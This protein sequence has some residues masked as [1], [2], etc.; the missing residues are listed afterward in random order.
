MN[1][2]LTWYEI[3]RT[4]IAAECYTPV[5]CGH[6]DANSFMRFDEEGARLAD[7]ECSLASEDF[8]TYLA[9]NPRHGADW[10][11]LIPMLCGWRLWRAGLRKQADYLEHCGRFESCANCGT[12]ERLHPHH[13]IQRPALPHLVADSTWALCETCHTTAHG[14]SI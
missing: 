8:E 11:R 10:P 7:L 12:T 13:V 9:K 4:V 14:G 3:A 6:V 5:D 2:E 1:D